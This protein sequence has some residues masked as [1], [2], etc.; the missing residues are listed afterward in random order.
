MTSTSIAANTLRKE[1]VTGSNALEALRSAVGV[2]SDVCEGAED[3][4]LSLRN[5]NIVHE[6]LQNDIDTI[7]NLDK[8]STLGTW[9]ELLPVL[10]NIPLNQLPVLSQVKV[11]AVLASW[12]QL[13][14]TINKEEKQTNAS[15]VAHMRLL[16]TYYHGCREGSAP[17][18]LIQCIKIMQYG[19]YNV[20]LGIS[21]NEAIEAT[22]QR[23]WDLLVKECTGWSRLAIVE[24]LSDDIPMLTALHNLIMRSKLDVDDVLEFLSPKKPS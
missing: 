24:M 7:V 18:L 9:D 11:S 10:Q 2:L 12:L 15:R 5:A 22:F 3:T 1:T 13:S 14:G 6:I 17:R 21:K 23:E 20:A 16:D 8:P 19:F 4:P